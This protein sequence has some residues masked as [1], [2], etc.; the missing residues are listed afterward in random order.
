MLNGDCDVESG[1]ESGPA[2]SLL[3]RESIRLARM[4]WRGGGLGMRVPQALLISVRW[5]LNCC[6]F[7]CSH[8][9]TCMYMMEVEEFH[10]RSAEFLNWLEAQDGVS[11]SPKIQ[12]TDL[13][14]TGAGRVVSMYAVL[15]D[16]PSKIEQYIDAALIF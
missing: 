9:L 16:H 13:R 2:L 15:F 11:I 6:A 14:S 8:L 3:V 4:A 7:V 5:T 12:L 1:M 10:S